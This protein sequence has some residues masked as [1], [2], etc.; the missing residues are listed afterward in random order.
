MDTPALQIVN[1][2]PRRGTRPMVARAVQD[3]IAIQHVLKKDI[4]D[5]K[6]TP[7]ARAALARAWATVQDSIRVMR[8]IPLPGQFRP[9]ELPSKKARRGKVIELAEEPR[10]APETPTPNPTPA[11]QPVEH[12]KKVCS[13]DTI[14]VDSPTQNTP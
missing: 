1:S 13:E 14:V 11:A 10:E 6:T 4:A 12:N 7:L 5:P 8:G 9:D 2:K 3:A